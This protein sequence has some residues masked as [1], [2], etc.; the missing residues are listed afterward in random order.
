MKQFEALRRGGAAWRFWHR[1][2]FVAMRVRNLCLPKFDFGRV[3]FW[4]YI[5]GE[6]GS[7]VLIMTDSGPRN[8]ER[9]VAQRCDY[10]KGS[11]AHHLQ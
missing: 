8:A 11:A 3:T 10:A 4:G 1:L 9:L 2:S 7:L 5:W 6:G